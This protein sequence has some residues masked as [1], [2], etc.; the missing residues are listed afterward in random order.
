MI[1]PFREIRHAGFVAGIAVIVVRKQIP[2]LVKSHFLRVP[3][4]ISINFHIRAIQLAT[5]HTACIRQ[6]QMLSFRCFDINTT[7]ADAEI[8]SA[9]RT[10][11]QSMQVVAEEADVDPE[12]VEQGFADIRLAIAVRVF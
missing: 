3:Q 1:R 10:N 12:A 8:Q 4:T 9:V 2:E 6:I 11:L 5:H 7:I